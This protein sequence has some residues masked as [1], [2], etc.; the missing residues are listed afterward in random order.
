MGVT[1]AQGS[2]VTPIAPKRGEKFEEIA[3]RADR[4]T[5][6]ARVD[7]N[8]DGKFNNGE[9]AGDTIKVF[10]FE[11]GRATGDHLVKR[12]ETG[13]STPAGKVEHSEV[14]LGRSLKK[15]FDGLTDEEIGETVP[16]AILVHPKGGK[17]FEPG[18]TIMFRSQDGTRHNIHYVK[19]GELP[20]TTAK[21]TGA[22]SI[23]EVKSDKG[24]MADEV[25]WFT[26]PSKTESK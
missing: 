15:T 14:A 16:G 2:T 13:V 8:G 12:G 17:K 20:A 1:P 23:N 24:I 22:K 19:N 10:D 21:M 7:G 5:V 25:V 6:V 11:K 9:T 18:A 4:K 26:M 3:K